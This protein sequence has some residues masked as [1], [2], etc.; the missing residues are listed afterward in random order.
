MSD[1]QIR[2]LTDRVTVKAPETVEYKVNVKYFVNQSD[3]KKVDTIKTAVN[4]AVDDYIQWQRSKIGRD[5]N[6][7]QLIQ[8]MVQPYV[9]KIVIGI[10]TSEDPLQVTLQNDININ[11]S[12]ISLTIPDRLKPINVGEY[13]YMFAFNNGKSYYMMDRVGEHG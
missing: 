11:L 2:P 1:E 13:F 5:I 7:S 4:A 10:V 6:P 9:P 12:A 3:L 8:Q